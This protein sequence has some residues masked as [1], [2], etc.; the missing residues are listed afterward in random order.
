LRFKKSLQLAWN[1]LAHSKLRSWLTIIGI[2]IGIAAV[3][4][5]V[6]ISEGAQQTMSDRFSG[7]GADI[8]TVS[9]GMSRAQGFG[10][11]FEGGPPGGQT[12][13]STDEKGL[14]SKDILVIKGLSN[15]K[16][17]MGSVSGRAELDYLGEG[18][19][20]NV[21]GVDTSVWKEINTNELESGRLLTKSD[22][23]SVVLGYEQAHK[24]FGKEVE[25]NRQISINGRLFKVVG[26]FK[27]GQDDRSVTIPIEIARGLIDNMDQ[28]KL[29]SITVKVADIN[30]LDDTVALITSKLMLSRGIIREDKRDFTVTSVKQLQETISS[31]LNMMAIF[32]GAIAAISLIVGGVGISNTMFTSVLEKTREI[33]VMKAI[34]AKNRDIMSIFLLNSGMIGFVGGLGGILLGSI[35]SGVV[36]FLVSGGTIS[37]MGPMR[38][39]SSTYLSPT[40]LISAFL[41]SIFIGMIAGAIPAY[42]ASKL[43]PV[44]ALRYE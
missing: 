42:N 1:L 9:S 12:A 40:L 30:K 8:L 14:T 35:A 36:T 22:T 17:V 18:G 2:V 24:F 28:T 26:I 43:N 44:D 16:F 3:V 5:I 15:V 37:T 25:V 33:G 21:K 10:G 34:G 7:L 19:E 38:M 32:L 6:S 41:F 13:T 29:G 4:A 27:E 39:L 31:T 11:H 23:Y 20:V